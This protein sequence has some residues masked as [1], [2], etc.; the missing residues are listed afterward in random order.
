MRPRLQIALDN[1][2]LEDA[3]TTLGG[4]VGEKMD[5]IE[6]GTLLLAAEGKR[7]ISVLRS[8]YPDKII[9]A[10]FKL[11][12]AAKVMAPM[13]LD[14]GADLV[15]VI[16]AADPSTMQIADSEAKK[17]GKQAQIELYGP[18]DFDRAKGWR[19]LGLSHII[20]HHSRDSDLPWGPADLEKVQGLCDLGFQV[21]VTGGI[22]SS[23]VKLFSG[24]PIF[25]FIGGRSIRECDNPVEEIDSFYREISC[26][27]KD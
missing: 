25:A 10:D 18:W 14:Q 5:I 23:H 17:R 1:T 26:C 6:A 24:M 15:T 11:A 7:A 13:F 8:L 2:S 12:D 22:N 19:E 21:T 9:V 27:W 20:Y 4:G 3:L 16:A